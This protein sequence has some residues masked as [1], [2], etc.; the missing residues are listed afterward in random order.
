MQSID[1]CHRFLCDNYQEEQLE[2]FD[3]ALVDSF[4]LEQEKSKRNTKSTPS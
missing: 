2:E 3:Q 1:H 4:G